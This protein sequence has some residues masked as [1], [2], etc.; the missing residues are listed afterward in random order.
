MYS[1]YKRCITGLKD[2]WQLSK[3]YNTYKMCIAGLKD[4]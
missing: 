2:V 1:T 4:V 3:M